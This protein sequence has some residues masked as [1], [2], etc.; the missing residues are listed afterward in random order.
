MPHSFS[1]AKFSEYGSLLPLLP[2]TRSP[3]AI[4]DLNG[5]PQSGS[6]LPYSKAPCGRKSYSDHFLI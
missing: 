5:K 4:E 1:D 3:F 6:K 2:F